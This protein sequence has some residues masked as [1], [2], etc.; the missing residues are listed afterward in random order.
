ML[1]NQIRT[2]AHLCQVLAFRQDSLSL[3]LDLPFRRLR[4]TQI[5]CKRYI[6]H[7]V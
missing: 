1:Q 5:C 2:S 7:F 6:K 3:K 4:A